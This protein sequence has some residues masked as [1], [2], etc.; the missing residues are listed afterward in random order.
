VIT[1]FV[2]VGA[3]EGGWPFFPSIVPGVC[4]LYVNLRV[5]P[6]MSA[7]EALGELDAQLRAL[8]AR[9]PDLRY[10]LE[11]YASNLP[12][13]VTPADSLLCRTAVEVMEQ[14]LGLPTR[15]FGPGEADPS[16]D[17]N[18]FRRHGI[19][20]IKC[21]PKTRLEPDAAE[22]LRLHGPHVHRDD[23]VLAAR[24]YVHMAFELCG[25]SR[26]ELQSPA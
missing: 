23:V 8:G 19:P 4:H 5:T 16:N 12:S 1:P 9:R 25:R 20:A 6:A 22:M 26:S 3:I 11:V 24:F 15:P 10:E 13:T 7:S 21:G 17:T 2:T 14:R 18:V